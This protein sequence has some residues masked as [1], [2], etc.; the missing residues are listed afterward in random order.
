MASVS[1]ITHSGV[2]DTGTV[3]DCESAQ[4]YR[5][6]DFRLKVFRLKG[7]RL[8]VGVQAEGV[9]VEGLR[10]VYLVYSV[11][12]VYL[13]EPDRPAFGLNPFSLNP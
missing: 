13:V 3:A 12:L 5:L 10:L 2:F 11:C 7:F 8:R 9:Q 6:T 1:Q 4:G